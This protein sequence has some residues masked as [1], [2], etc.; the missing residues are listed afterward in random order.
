MGRAKLFWNGQSQA[1]R[2]PKDCR[3]E[4]KE[5][6]IR[7]VGNAVILLPTD[8]PWAP[9][10]ASLDDFSE[11]LFEEGRKQGEQESRDKFP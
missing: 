9:L 6:L 3:F 7:K 1:V 10:V 11:D 5:V 2:L 4:G 8:D